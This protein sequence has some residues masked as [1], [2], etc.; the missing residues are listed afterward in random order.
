MRMYA[1]SLSIPQSAFIADGFMLKGLFLLGNSL[2]LSKLSD[3][4]PKAYVVYYF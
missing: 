4:S 1:K 3:L 2:R